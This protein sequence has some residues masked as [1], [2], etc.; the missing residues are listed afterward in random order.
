MNTVGIIEPPR[1]PCNPRN[2][3]MLWM[4]QAHPHN[5]LVAV[6]S[7]A[8]M[9]NSHRVDMTLD[10]HPDNGMTVILGDEVAGLHPRDLIWT[11][12]QSAADLA[13]RSRDKI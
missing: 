8:E 13:E 1:K 9:E 6:N 2:T 5:K 3:I 7:A 12:R 10:N 11:G 4:S